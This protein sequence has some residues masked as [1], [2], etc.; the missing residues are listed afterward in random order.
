MSKLDPENVLMLCIDG[1]RRKDLLSGRLPKLLMWVKKE[2]YFFENAYSSSTT[3]YESLIPVYGSNHDMRSK[4]YEKNVLE[5]EE[6]RFIREALKQDRNIFFYTDTDQFINCKRIVR[7]GYSQTVTEKIWDFVV[8]ARKEHNG[9][10]YVHVLYESH[11]SYP[12]PYTEVPMI[13]DGSTILH[14]FSESKG[15][16]IRTDYVRQQRD[17]LQYV[18][19]VLSPFLEVLPCRT[20]LFADHGNIL[21]K[22][23]DSLKELEVEKYTCHKDWIEVPIVIKC[24]ELPP[25]RD[26]RL[27]SL[28]ELNNI[29]CCLLGKKPYVYSEEEYIK[30][31][32]SRLYNPELQYVYSKNGHEKELQAFE[33]FIFKGGAQLMVFENGELKVLYETEGECKTDIVTLYQRVAADITVSDTVILKDKDFV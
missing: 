26:K 10:F 14:D 2:G 5:E 12:N 18:D 4:Y 11:F 23:S 21:M 6:C 17:A 32:R 28:M 29:I 20:V 33:L 7:S 9:L 19:D 13:A 15:G 22:E 25:Y 8:D 24:P 16:K 27:I 31:Q 30:V 3:T 1:L